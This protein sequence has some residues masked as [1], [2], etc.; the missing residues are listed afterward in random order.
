MIDQRL[1]G[2]RA[3]QVV[4]VSGFVQAALELDGNE[5]AEEYEALKRSAP[6]RHAAGRRYFVRHT[7]VAGTTGSN[8]AEEHLAADL[9]SR[10]PITTY[11]G[12]LELLDFQF[13]L[14]AYRSDQ[15]LG[16]VDLLGL[17]NSLVIVE[18]KVIR[19]GGGGDTPL[20]A[21]LEAL[22]YAAVVEANHDDIA[23]EMAELGWPIPVGRP[24]VLVLG[25]GTYWDRWDNSRACE[26]WREALDTVSAELRD[27]V[28]ID[29]LFGRL[30]GGLAQVHSVLE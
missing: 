9:M 4:Q 20:G 3:S 21:L 12:P 14:K 18:L 25:P 17:L 10:S 22:A 29:F 23:G 28:G 7:S 13:P 11:R 2:R 15:G 19:P 6:R 30:D 1:L 27:A 8:R 16:K 26:G 24:D 5:L